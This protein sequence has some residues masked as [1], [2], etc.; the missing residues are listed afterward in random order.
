MLKFILENFSH[1]APILACGGFGLVIIFERSAALFLAYP[2]GEFDGFFE[3]VRTLIMKDRIS[4]AVAL[5][6]RF[7]HK[8]AARVVREGL[9]RA[10]QPEELIEHGLQIAV[11]Q[12]LGKIQART[13][14]LATIANVATLF[15]LLGTIIGLVQSFE[16]VGSANAQQ[17]SAMLAQGISTAMNA[18]MLGLAIAIPS[19]I[20]Y[21]I[22]MNKTNKLTSQ[23]D[24]AAMRTLD[25]LGQRYFTATGEGNP[26]DEPTFTGRMLKAKR[27]QA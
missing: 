6:E 24:Q 4:E 11:S 27:R 10:H 12:G 9:V 22:L 16:A 15:G 25:L 17:R 19:M 26:G 20:A 21:A 23:L 14:F 3:R 13:A 8:P 2:L 7:R 5:C 18:T 1:V